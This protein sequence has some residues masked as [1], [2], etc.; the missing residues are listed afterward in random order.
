MTNVTDCMTSVTDCATNLTD[1]SR[2]CPSAHCAASSMQLH[3][4]AA[5]CSLCSRSVCVALK[6]REGLSLIDVPLHAC[7]CCQC[8]LCPFAVSVS[9]SAPC[10]GSHLFVCSGRTDQAQSLPL[11]KHWLAQQLSDQEIQ[12]CFTTLDRD[13]N[14]LASLAELKS[15]SPLLNRCFT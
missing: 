8:C 15:S 10:C 5:Q 2:C 7:L 4:A 11:K 9:V 1:S 6:V 12:D 14:G 13:S 3:C